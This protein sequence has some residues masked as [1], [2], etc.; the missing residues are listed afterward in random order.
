[1]C[2]QE[3]GI[4]FRKAIKQSHLNITQMVSASFQVLFGL[5]V[6]EIV[7]QYEHRDLHI[8]NVLVR[9]TRQTNATFVIKSKS[10]SV[11]TYGIHA[12]II[13]NTFSR[14]CI[15]QNVYYTHISHN[16]EKI[17]AKSKDPSK[18]LSEQDC[19]YV[20]MHQMAQNN[21]AKWMPRTNLLWLHYL[22]S[23]ILRCRLA[24]IKRG[25]S[26]SAHNKLIRS[27][28]VVTSK[29][30]TA[31]RLEEVLECVLTSQFVANT[32]STY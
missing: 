13:D 21:W 3:C 28:Q 1:M 16:L 12:F 27:F 17:V 6:A 11:P 4:S 30:K 7:Y 2:M 15:G 24:K 5:I 20:Q 14:M 8:N 9:W 29:L 10:Y 23:Q 19:I 18:R 26:Y 32:T 31:S 22:F 25:N